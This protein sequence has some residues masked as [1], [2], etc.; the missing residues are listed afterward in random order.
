MASSSPHNARSSV[1]ANNPKLRL[2]A[3]TD[4]PSDSNP[5]TQKVWLIFGATGHIGRSLV[6]SA[7]SHGD[8]VTAVGRTMENS[9]QQMQGWHERCFGLLCDVRVRSTVEEVIRKSIDRWSRID[10]IVN[11]TGYGV[12]GACEDQD[13]SD[14]RSQFETNFLGTLNIIQLSLPHLRAQATRRQQD[15]ENAGRYIIFSSTSG[16]LGVP[17][18]GPYCA[19]KYATEG[20]I[21]SML[22]E[23]DAFGIR[24]SLVEP[25]HMRIDE[26]TGLDDKAADES[27]AIKKY[28]HFLVKPPS[29]PYNTPTA[30]AGHARRI[31]QWLSDRQPTS[32]VKSA[33][34]VWQLGHCKYPP[35]RLVLGTYAV[36]SVR[37]R[38]RSVIEEIEDWKHLHFPGPEDEGKGKGDGK[39]DEKPE[40]KDEDAM[41]VAE[42]GGEVKDEDEELW[43]VSE[44]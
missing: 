3:T 32:A 33:E 38:L 14:L 23:I 19:T 39:D 42:D 28:G 21:E 36:E 13:D 40:D 11:C 6:K 29:A 17:G 16:A 1:L 34:L 7:L 15:D 2:P 8:N 44:P 18:L 12:I 26:P 43:A 25:G 22:Y 9:M 24:A 30:P 4:P 5:A 20:L 27:F 37:D 41:D 31:V 10:V 35:L